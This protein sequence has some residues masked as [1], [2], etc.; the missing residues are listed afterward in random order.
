[1][2]H[3]HMAWGRGNCKDARAVTAAVRPRAE[4]ENRRRLRTRPRGVRCGG[5]AM[6]LHPR[7]RVS[8]TPIMW[9]KPEGFKVHALQHILAAV[10]SVG[11]VQKGSEDIKERRQGRARPGKA[12]P[13]V[14]GR[15]EVHLLCLCYYPLLLALDWKHHMCFTKHG[16]IDIG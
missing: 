14:R 7:R 15:G 10:F 13:A 11:C 2:T 12:R 16:K 6:P 3:G 5:H 9:T 1:M 8:P 4:H